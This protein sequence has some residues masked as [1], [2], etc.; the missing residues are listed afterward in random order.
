MRRTGN[1]S[2]SP[3]IGMVTAGTSKI[4]FAPDW[5]SAMR[6][7]ATVPASA[8]VPVARRDLRST[9]SIRVLLMLLIFRAI[10]RPYSGA[11]S[12]YDR[13]AGMKKAREIAGL[14][15][16]CEKSDHHLTSAG[17]LPPF[18]ASLDITCL[19]NQI[20][21]LAESLVSPG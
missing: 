9:V 20:F 3:A 17:N 8:N 14:L 12:Q 4:G 13:N 16:S 10:Y 7:A 6:L 2:F 18:A 1:T 11:A 15:P 21:M 5:A 19:C